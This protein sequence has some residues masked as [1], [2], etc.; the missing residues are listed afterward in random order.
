MAIWLAKRFVSSAACAA[1]KSDPHPNRTRT[2]RA[3]APGASDAPCMP[4]WVAISENEQKKLQTESADWI[5]YRSAYPSRR[6]IGRLN[7]TRRPKPKKP[8]QRA[9]HVHEQK[10]E[11]QCQQWVLVPTVIPVPQVTQ[12]LA[13]APR[14][15]NLFAMDPPLQGLHEHWTNIHRMRYLAEKHP[16]I[17][18]VR[19]HKTTKQ[20]IQVSSTRMDA[21]KDTTRLPSTW[22]LYSQPLA[23]R[24]TP[25]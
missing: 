17:G 24:C 19:E 1:T 23:R 4:Q 2:S 3:A 14:E 16:Q 11:H 20:T 15:A 13:G 22:P 25:A 9:W 10:N 7:F 18:S 5:A 12:P 6:N 8:D 21:Q